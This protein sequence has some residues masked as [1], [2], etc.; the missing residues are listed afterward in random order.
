MC[1]SRREFL[2]RAGVAA[3]A[4]TAGLRAAGALRAAQP[5][6]GK[7]ANAG[8]SLGSYRSDWMYQAKWGVFMHYLAARADLPVAEWNRRIDGFDVEAL[9]R[10]IQSAGA[11]YFFITL[12]Q[13]SGHYLAPNA[14]YD[15]F[16]GIRPSKCS[17]RD[18]VAD[19]HAALARRKVNLMVYLP[20]GA[21]DRDPTAMERLQWRKGPYR[22]AEFQRKWQQVIAEWSQQWGGKVRGWW[23][24]GC[25]W[26][27]AMYRSSAPPNFG[28]FADAAREGNT[29]SAVAFNPGVFYPIFAEAPEEDYTAGEINDVARVHCRSRW[30]DGAQ[31][32]MLSFLGSGWSRGEPRFAAARAAQTTTRIVQPGGVVTWDVPHGPTGRISD[33]FMRQLEAIGEAVARIKRQGN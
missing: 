1:P 18:L 25:Y 31:F 23:F 33:A 28:S 27:N 14:T 17:R 3:G 29:S 7:A 22:N 4:I 30:V 5:A 9:A 24:D 16:V 15:S 11:G 32:H 19:L 13:N 20:A 8:E 6:S 10:Q 2:K 12:G 21:P 26:P